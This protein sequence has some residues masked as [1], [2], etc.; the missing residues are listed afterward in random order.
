MEQ[1]LTFVITALGAGAIGAWFGYGRGCLV[2]VESVLLGYET[3][4]LEHSQKKKLRHLKV[5]DDAGLELGRTLGE[6]YK[7]AI[8]QTPPVM[9]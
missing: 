9:H 7:S 5:P 4:I 1:F 6:R 8:D 2:G 3:V